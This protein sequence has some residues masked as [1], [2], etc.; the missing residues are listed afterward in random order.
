MAKE[1]GKLGSSRNDDEES[2]EKE[3]GDGKVHLCMFLFVYL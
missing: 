1:K 2:R 3:I